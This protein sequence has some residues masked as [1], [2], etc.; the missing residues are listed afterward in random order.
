[1]VV[2]LVATLPTTLLSRMLK[3]AVAGVDAMVECLLVVLL[4]KNSMIV[5][6]ASL[7]AAATAVLVIVKLAESFAP[8][9]QR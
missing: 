4:M 8:L 3:P 2:A 5:Y 9:A 7:A 6:L 1:M